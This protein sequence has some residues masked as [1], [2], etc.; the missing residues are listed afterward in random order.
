MP[1]VTRIFSS[2]LLCLI[3]L[4]WL[5][6]CSREHKTVGANSL[7]FPVILAVGTS[8]STTIPSHADVIFNIQDLSQMRVALYSTLSDAS[9]SNPPILIDSTAAAFEMRN[10]KG[11]HG[12]TWIVLNPNGLMPIRFELIPRAES[13]LVVARA[14]LEN[15]KYLGSDLD[16]ERTA[17]RRGRI[18]LAKNIADIMLLVNEIPHD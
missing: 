2:N 9:Q 10:I 16:A 17:V 3:T 1:S 14:V 12:G 13:G 7:S 11:E 18:R 8:T 6:A 15:C 5:A 4:G